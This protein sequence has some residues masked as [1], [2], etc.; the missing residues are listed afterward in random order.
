[1]SELQPMAIDGQFAGFRKELPDGRTIDVT[2]MLLGN[3]R[4]SVGRDVDSRGYD[5]Q[6]CY[7]S[8]PLAMI[9]AALW[10]GTGE[11][12]GWKRHPGTGRRRPNGDP[13]QEYVAR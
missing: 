13:E 9:A 5:D 8:V 3:G 4:I 11:P 6:W 10:D 12:T 2:P 7:D 1:M